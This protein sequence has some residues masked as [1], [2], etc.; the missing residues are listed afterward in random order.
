MSGTVL[1]ADYN[2]GGNDEK[3]LFLTPDEFYNQI[4]VVIYKKTCG[5]YVPTIDDKMVV[6]LSDNTDNILSYG[7]DNIDVELLN[8][9]SFRIAAAAVKTIY[10]KSPTEQNIELYNGMRRYKYDIRDNDTSGRFHDLISVAKCE[11]LSMYWAEYTLIV[12]NGI[13]DNWPF[14]NFID[15]RF[16]D[17]N[18][19]KLGCRAVHKYIHSNKTDRAAKKTEKHELPVYN[20]TVYDNAGNQIYA[21]QGTPQYEYISGYVGSKTKLTANIDRA[22]YNFEDMQAAQEADKKRALKTMQLL[23]TA[24]EFETV[25]LLDQG[26]TV[27]EIADKLNVSQPAISGRLVNIRKKLRTSG[28]F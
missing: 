7:P 4:D 10:R 1:N 16:I 15:N 5:Q 18:C 6:I 13:S 25:L 28:K 23:L 12:N 17:K 24:I 8:D 9:Y 14:K 11:L 22:F 2:A 19:F 20:C 26:L 27:C 3:M 21:A